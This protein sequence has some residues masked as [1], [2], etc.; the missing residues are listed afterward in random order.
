MCGFYLL[1]AMEMHAANRGC[2]PLKRVD[3]SAT[4]HVPDFECAIRAARDD[5]V[6]GHLGRPNAT[7]VTHQSS[8]TL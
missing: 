8:Q 2:M 6:S 5:D 1:A 4:V 7:G 3:A